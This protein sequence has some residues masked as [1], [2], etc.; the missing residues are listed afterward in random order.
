[1]ALAGTYFQSCT[2]RVCGYSLT[3]GDIGGH[4]IAPQLIVLQAEGLQAWQSPGPALGKRSSERI[5]FQLPA[6]RCRSQTQ[7]AEAHQAMHTSCMRANRL[8]PNRC[9]QPAAVSFGRSCKTHRIRSVV[10]AHLVGSGPASRFPV[11]SSVVICSRPLSKPSGR[12]P[13]IRF[14]ESSS[15]LSAGSATGA[16]Q[17]AGKLPLRLQFR[18]SLQQRLGTLVGGCCSAGM[19]STTVGWGGQHIT[20][21]L[22]TSRHSRQAAGTHSRCSA[23]SAPA[24]PQVAGRPPLNATPSNLTIRNCCRATQESARRVGRSKVAG[25]DSCSCS[26]RGSPPISSMNAPDR[27]TGICES[28]NSRSL[29]HS[30]HQGARC[31]DLAVVEEGPARGPARRDGG[32]GSALTGGSRCRR[33]RMLHPARGS[34]ACGAAC[35]SRGWGS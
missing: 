23:G 5:F 2:N 13:V 11:R 15:V 7:Q 26:R 30:K 20:A 6:S 29:Q 18:N 28:L 35:S 34:A 33:H 16:A 3:S 4:A 1:M 14:E 25:L 9:P 8:Q 24:W 12:L 32:V 17:A 10:L 31:G 21:M 22:G 27:R 19:S